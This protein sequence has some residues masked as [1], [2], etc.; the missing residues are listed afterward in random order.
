M[1]KIILRKK[2]PPHPLLRNTAWE[3]IRDLGRM[4]KGDKLNTCTAKHGHLGKD[5]S[6]ERWKGSLEKGD[7]PKMFTGVKKEETN[8]W[9]LRVICKQGGITEFK[10]IAI[11]HLPPPQK[12]LSFNYTRHCV[13]CTN[14]GALKLSLQPKSFPHPLTHP[15]NSCYCWAKSVLGI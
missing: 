5:T 15:P 14:S 10:D 11:L 1:N 13:H 9:K 6:S 7:I 2:I 4:Q 12:K 8:I 3:Y